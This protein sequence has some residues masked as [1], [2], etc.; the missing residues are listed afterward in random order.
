MSTFKIIIGPSTELHSGVHG[1]LIENP[2]PGI[3]YLQRPYQ[4][5]YL[6]RDVSPFPLNPF[7]ELSVCESVRYEMPHLTDCIV[8]SSRI[9]VYNLVPWVVDMDCLLGTL[10]YGQFFGIGSK[11]RIRAGDIDRESAILRQKIM[12]SLYLSDRCKGIFFRTDYSRHLAIQY[13]RR[14]GL[15]DDRGLDLLQKKMEVIYPTLPA[16]SISTT[17]ERFITV[18]YMGRTF[19]DKGGDIALET[20]AELKQRFRQSIELIFISDIHPKLATRHPGI[21]ILPA[22]ER[23]KYLGILERSQIFFSPT[24]FESYGMALV[25]AACY[26]MAIITTNGYGMEH[27][28]ELFEKDCNAFMVPN[29]WPKERKVKEFVRLISLLIDNRE[30]LRVMRENNCRLVKQGRLSLG[31]RDKKLLNFY[32]KIKKAVKD[33]G[34]CYEDDLIE[35]FKNKHRLSSKTFSEQYCWLEIALRTRGRQLRVRL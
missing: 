4:Y 14:A 10:Q 13:I 26:G 23:E 28:E 27:I 31:I 33:G 20:F 2:P 19:K 15:I 12:L 6:F 24:T 16:K 9:P 29:E 7:D 11:E 17:D 25:E 3:E 32:E 22:V 21:T 35:E 8:H 30:K 5:H 34:A 1:S 18:V